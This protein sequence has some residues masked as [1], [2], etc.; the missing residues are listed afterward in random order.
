MIVREFLGYLKEVALELFTQLVL[1]VL[2]GLSLLYFLII[3]E[4]RRG[5]FFLLGCCCLGHICIA[6][7]NKVIILLE[8][9]GLNCVQK[10]GIDMLSH[11][12]SEGKNRVN[13]LSIELGL[14][15]YC[16]L[17]LFVTLNGRLRYLGSGTGQKLPLSIFRTKLLGLSLNS[18]LY[19][20]RYGRKEIAYNNVYVSIVGR[21]L[22]AL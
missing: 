10:C 1:L 17:L 8:K 3:Q 14:N 12:Y 21:R 22:F 20:H 7:S 6:L 13:S 2:D 18:Y 16:R 19:F 4:N 5:I 9:A 11:L 15:C